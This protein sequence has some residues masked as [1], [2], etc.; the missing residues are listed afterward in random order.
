MELRLFNQ[1][2][3]LK[4]LL[5]QHRGKVRMFINLKTKIKKLAQIAVIQAEKTLGSNTGKQKKEMAINFIIERI[6]VPVILKPLVSLAFSSFI[7]E[8]IEFAVKY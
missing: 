3:W 1:K 6:P 5:V 2:L 8:A 7:D 4:W